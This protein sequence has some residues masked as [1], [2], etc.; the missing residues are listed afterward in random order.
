MKKTLKMKRVQP[1]HKSKG[2]SSIVRILNR[3]I[4]QHNLNHSL[5]SQARISFI[6]IQKHT[7]LDQARDSCRNLQI[8][9]SQHHVVLLLLLIPS[10]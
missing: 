9:S 3:L 1:A 7:H 8:L 2:S 4:D 10:L 6:N 5:N